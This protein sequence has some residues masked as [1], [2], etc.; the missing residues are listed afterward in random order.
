MGFKVE[1][2]FGDEV[3]LLRF[4]GEV[5]CIGAGFKPIVGV[6]VTM[7]LMQVLGK[8]VAIYIHVLNQC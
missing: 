1:G 2:F 6:H 4:L 3:R 5:G 8:C 7:Q